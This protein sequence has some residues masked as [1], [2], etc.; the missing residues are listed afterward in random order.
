MTLLLCMLFAA[1]DAVV[2]QAMEDEMARS[3]TQL[4]LGQ[5]NRMAMPRD[6]LAEPFVDAFHPGCPCRGGC[7]GQAGLSPGT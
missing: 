5:S 1:N 2:R 3:L 4:R 7:G 6:P